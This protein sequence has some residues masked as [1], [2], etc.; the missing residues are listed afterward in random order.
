MA[1]TFVDDPYLSVNGVDYSDY[2]Q[3]ITLTGGRETIE[4]TAGGDGGRINMPG[5]RIWRCEVTLKE[6]LTDG[7]IDEAIWVLA[8][9]GTVFILRV[10][11]TTD[12]VSAT[13]PE[14]VTTELTGLVATAGAIVDG[15]YD[16]VTGT[17]GSLATK[18]IA[19][20][21]GASQ[22]KLTRTVAAI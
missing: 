2:V 16:L 6:D 21:P 12:V 19:F 17:V 22:T 7:G 5:L 14:W 8:D 11:P 15:A 10:R 4:K 18:T 9:A 20:V 13:N 1:D 3:S